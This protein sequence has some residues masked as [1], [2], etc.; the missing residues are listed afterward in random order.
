MIRFAAFG[1]RSQILTNGRDF[2]IAVY[3]LVDLFAFELVQGRPQKLDVLVYVGDEAEFHAGRRG[4]ATGW[5]AT[6]LGP[7][8]FRTL[9]GLDDKTLDGLLAQ[10]GA[11]EGKTRTEKRR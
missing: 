4:F 11:S 6:S 10:V 5:C 1:S 3:D 7:E 2:R 8:A 9:A